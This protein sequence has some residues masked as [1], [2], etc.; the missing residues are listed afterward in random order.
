MQSNAQ[1]KSNWNK[2]LWGGR[3]RDQRRQ[4]FLW[5]E[6]LMRWA[7]TWKGFTIINSS[8]SGRFIRILTLNNVLVTR[9]RRLAG[10]W[11]RDEQTEAT[12]W[13]FSGGETVNE[14]VIELW[15][16]NWIANSTQSISI[17]S[18]SVTQRISHIQTISRSSPSQP[19]YQKLL[20]SHLQAAGPCLTLKSLISRPI[21][22]KGLRDNEIK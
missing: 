5:F 18:R 10:G 3:E 12:K 11:Q 2:R 7:F 6:C 9:L 13:R 15:S 19:I 17:W 20:L 21:D 22:K 14:V 16:F 4:R 8:F 1:K